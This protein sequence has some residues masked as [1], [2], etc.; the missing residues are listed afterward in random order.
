MRWPGGWPWAVWL[1]G[2]PVASF[3]AAQP[4]GRVDVGL[5]EAQ[6]ERSEVLFF[7]DFE[8]ANTLGWSVS[9]Q[10][11]ITLGAW[12]FGDPI[13]TMSDSVPAQPDAPFE[14]T[15]CAYTG[16]NPEALPGADDVDD[17]AVYLT[18]PAID[19]SSAASARL[20]YVRWYYNRDVGED[21]D[22]DSDYFAVLAS[23]DDGQTWVVLEYL[24]YWASVNTWTSREVD[25]EQF[26]DLTETV[27]LRIAASDG[28]REGSIV[29]A[30]IDNVLITTD[31][32]GLG[33]GD[34]DNDGDVDVLDFRNFQRC[35]GQPGTGNCAPADLAE[36]P[37]I[38]TADFAA[39]VVALTGPD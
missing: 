6:A 34:F 24:D 28:I 25:L 10:R 15:G 22:Y 19:L 16:E 18:S 9:K 33:D 3:C 20:S 2:L 12:V 35:F 13:G 11:D 7:D 29:E 5:G 8:D 31:S 21:P 27:R 4:A 30:A 14:G 26:I 17:G 1:I 36:G 37:L 23:D 39:F 38:D 32:P